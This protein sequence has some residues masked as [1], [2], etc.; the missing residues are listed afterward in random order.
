MRAAVYYR[1]KAIRV[2]DVKDPEIGHDHEIL[3]Q[4]DATSISASERHIYRGAVDPIMEKGSSRTGHELVG[5]VIGVGR[6]VSRVKRGE[7][8]T[9][10]Y[11]VQPFMQQSLELIES[12][13]V[14][15]ESYFTYQF[16][17]NAIDQA[18]ARFFEKGDGAMKML[19]KN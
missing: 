7:R 13:A 19:I 18:F 5:K 15:L 10:A 3:V 12:G 6:S 2:T 11:S 8:V 9:M 4:I 17:L 16:G 14:D 1:P